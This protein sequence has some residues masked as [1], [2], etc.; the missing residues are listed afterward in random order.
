MNFFGL[1]AI[2]FSALGGGFDVAF[3]SSPM[4]Y[5]RPMSQTV[6]VPLSASE[7]I[8]ECGAARCG[9]TAKARI[10]PE[11]FLARLVPFACG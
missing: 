4:P 3:R 9:K 11:Q 6:T 7:L 2:A 10:D 8:K 5:Y 1:G